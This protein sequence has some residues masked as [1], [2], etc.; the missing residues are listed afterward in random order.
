[1]VWVTSGV[2]EEL[3]T[4]DRDGWSRY[5]TGC[6]ILDPLKRGDCYSCMQIGKH[7]ITLVHTACDEGG[8]E[9]CSDFGTEY[10]TDFLQTPYSKETATGHLIDHEPHSP[11]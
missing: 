6:G 11:V 2:F 1:M 9:T 3:G 10:T 8:N 4:R 5:K 7:R